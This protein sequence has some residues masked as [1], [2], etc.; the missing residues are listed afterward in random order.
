MFES[1]GFCAVMHPVTNQ[2]LMNKPTG[3]TSQRPD[4]MTSIRTV[5]LKIKQLI[6][7][8]YE[9]GCPIILRNCSQI[10]T[11]LEADVTQI[12]FSNKKKQNNKNRL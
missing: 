9:T 12:Y 3:W 10:G 1:E 6:V 8:A 5:R 7:S 2:W 11:Q 4:F